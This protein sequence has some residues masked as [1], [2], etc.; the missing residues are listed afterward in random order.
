LR[1]QVAEGRL[2]RSRRDAG[3][4]RRGRCCRSRSR[5]RRGLRWS[6][7]SRRATGDGDQ[8]QDDQPPPKD[9]RCCVSLDSSH[10]NRTGRTPSEAKCN[11]PPWRP[12]IR[13]TMIGCA[14][15][16]TIADRDPSAEERP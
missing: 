8:S 2:E 6:W 9:G 10:W 16:R 1:C 12:A 5:R 7:W 13:E 4:R 14:P 11:Q 3:C 15:R